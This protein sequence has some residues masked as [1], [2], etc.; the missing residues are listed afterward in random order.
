M[1]QKWFIYLFKKK[2]ELQQHPNKII[3]PLVDTNMLHTTITENILFFICQKYI[4]S[5]D[6]YSTARTSDHNK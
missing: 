1:Y 5:D 3:Q 2:L 6:I 4:I